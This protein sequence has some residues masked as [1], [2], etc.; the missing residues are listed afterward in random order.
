MREGKSEQRDHACGY[1]S[2]CPAMVIKEAYEPPNATPSDTEW[3]ADKPLAILGY[4]LIVVF[5]YLSYDGFNVHHGIGEAL[6]LFP[7]LQ[8]L[9]AK[10]SMQPD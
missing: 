4:S 1:R 3:T 9:P 6:A 8:N 5:G 2:D 10:V 7:V